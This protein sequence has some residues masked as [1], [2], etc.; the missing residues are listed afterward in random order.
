M[1]FHWVSV[2]F[3]LFCSINISLSEVAHWNYADIGPDVWEDS[4]P[5]C[6]RT[7]QSPI[8]ILT[9]CT[10]Y[11]EFPTFQFSP[12][13]NVTQNFT[14]T[15]NGHTITALQIDSTAFPLTLSGGGLNGTFQFVNLHFHWGENY[16]SGS[17]HQ[18]N[19]EKYGGEIHFVYLNPANNLY[20]VLG[21]FFQSI[22]S[23]STSS[24]SSGHTR[25]KR[26]TKREINSTNN[27]ASAPWDSYLATADDLN[28]TNDSVVISLQ[29]STLMNTDFSKF[30]RYSGSLTTPPCSES[31]IWSV[32]QTPIQLRDDELEIFRLNI[33]SENYRS[34]QPL[35]GR[36]VY[37]SFQN[38]TSPS[39][40]LYT[41]CT[42]TGGKNSLNKT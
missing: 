19:G 26:L 4:Y 42:Q 20:A 2:V 29:L 7:I 12:D 31:V 10:V 17:E 24:E 28:H 5:I 3:I 30:Y 14:V 21:I 18:I 16:K 15:N 34:T 38:D 27:E 11:N 41:C 9:A 23:N 8:N 35:N 39:A 40:Y 6:A 32:F 22:K 37:R 25:K 13:T 36:T 1:H 33:F